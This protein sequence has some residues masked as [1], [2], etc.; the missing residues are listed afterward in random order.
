MDQQPQGS[1][2]VLGWAWSSCTWRRVRALTPPIELFPGEEEG[3]LRRRRSVFRG[4]RLGYCGGFVPGKSAW[5]QLSGQWRTGAPPPL[6]MWV[7]PQPWHI[8]VQTDPRRG[9]GAGDLGLNTEGGNVGIGGGR[10]SS[11][12]IS[13]HHQGFRTQLRAEV[14]E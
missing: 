5:E 9:P 10:V 3:F 11:L 2:L 4:S 14:N 1:A 8:P 6:R 12:T 13:G 7:R